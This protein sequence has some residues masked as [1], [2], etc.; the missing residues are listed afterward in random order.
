[1]SLSKSF[2]E[3]KDPVDAYIIRETLNEP[4]LLTELLNYTVANVPRAQ[5]I[6]DPIQIQLFRMLL[7][8][9]NAVKCIEVGSFTGYNVLNC[10]LTIPENG[11]VY[12]LDITD[13]FISHGRQFFEKAGVSQKIKECIGPASETLQKFIDE[14]HEGTFDFIYVD[15]DKT[16][17]P[18]YYDLGIQLLRPG[19]VLALDNTL[20]WGLMVNPEAASLGDKENVAAMAEVTRKARN[21]ERVDISFLKIGDGVCLCRKR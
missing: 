4:P 18:L 13:E 15:A 12:A 16:G 19:G 10:A 21:D 7:K 8:M 11:I 6:S 20:L 1:M 2:M 14:G 17:Y 9:L 3:K 5:M